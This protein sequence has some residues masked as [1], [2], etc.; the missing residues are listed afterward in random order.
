MPENE[1]NTEL[2]NELKTKSEASFETKSEA[3]PEAGSKSEPESEKKKVTI[4]GI[5]NNIIALIT[6]RLF[7][8]GLLIFLGIR[9]ALNPTSAP[10]KIAWGLGLAILIAT[11]GLFITFITTKSFNRTNLV[12]I[13]ETI[14]FTVLGG[15]MII[16]SSAFGVV[17]EEIICAAIIVNCTANLLCL[18]NFDRMRSTLD[19]K[20]EKRR[21]KNS[22]NQVVTEVGQSIKDDFAKYNGELLNAAAHVKKKANATTLGQITLNVVLIIAAFVMLFTRFS[23]AKTLYLISGIILVLSGLNDG[24]LVIRGYL[25]KRRAVKMAAEADETV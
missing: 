1:L 20:A 9:V 17:L 18:R 24:A 21:E 19:A 2:N 6:S 16:F 12:P 14:L 4:G 23:D 8:A 5:V 13:I 10:S 7:T 11:V 22:T 3:E 15:C 25:E